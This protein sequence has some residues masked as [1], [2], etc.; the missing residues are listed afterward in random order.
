MV[1]LG[2]NDTLKVTMEDM[3]HHVKAVTRGVS[4]ALVIADL[5]FLSYQVSVAE[6]VRNAGRMFQE[7]G[8]GAVKLE[9]GIP[10]LPQVR[11]IV[12][13]GMPVMG[14]LGLTPQSVHQFGGYKVQAREKQA[15]IQLLKDALA[16][17]EAGV[18]SIVLE[19]VPAEIAA[20][21]T[22]KLSVLT[23]GIGAGAGCS[24][25]VLVI[26]DM[27]G[28]GYDENAENAEERPVVA[29]RFVKSY[30]RMGEMAVRGIRAY[31]DEV[32]A[33]TFPG[34]E[35][36]YRVD[37]QVLAELENHFNPGGDVK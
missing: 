36:T 34:P 29:P 17:Q 24:G 37:P 12:A 22:R 26:N 15:A 9:G 21:I 3:L 13:A 30:A 27:L 1:C 5:P 2:Y 6:A 33:G 4:R 28:M 31:A 32:R 8:A 19:C 20:L 7:G 35:H 10:V 25:Q 11:A 18:F 14:H 23:I 16:L